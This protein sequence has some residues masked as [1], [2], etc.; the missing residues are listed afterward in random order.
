M[1]CFIRGPQPVVACS[2]AQYLSDCACCSFALE[3]SCEDM[4]NKL[5]AV[6]SASHHL[7]LFLLG[8]GGVGINGLSDWWTMIVL[9]KWLTVLKQIQGE[10][11]GSSCRTGLRR[12]RGEYFKIKL[13]VQSRQSI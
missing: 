4:C 13:S 10:V 9:Y 1:V 3:Y 5:P 2:I 6:I 11:G 7:P 12:V 8:I